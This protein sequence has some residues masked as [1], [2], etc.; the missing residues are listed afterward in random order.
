MHIDHHRPLGHADLNRRQAETVAID[1]IQAARTS[2][3][4]DQAFQFV[5][6]IQSAYVLGGQY[7]AA[8]AFMDRIATALGDPS[9]RRT[10]DEIRREA[11]AMLGSQPGRGRPAPADTTN[12]S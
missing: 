4:Q 1:Q 5:Q 8:S 3:A 9:L 11:E 10:A 6:Y 12:P 7:E 2:A